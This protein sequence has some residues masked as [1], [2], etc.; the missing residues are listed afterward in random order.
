MHAADLSLWIEAK[1]IR[2]GPLKTV[3]AA[4]YHEK[5][6]R[7]G[8]DMRFDK[9]TTKFQQAFADAQSIAVGADN[10]YIEPQ[11]LLLALMNQEDGA[12]KS[13]LGRAGANA[14]ALRS[15]LER[16]IERLPRVEGAEIGRAHV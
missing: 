6:S 9:F 7:D 10:P 8:S 5:S 15:A 3:A 1:F 4:Q 14:T 11:H 16:S 13:L 2:A 12:T